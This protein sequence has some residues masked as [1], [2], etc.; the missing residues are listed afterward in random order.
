MTEVCFILQ[1][2]IIFLIAPFRKM[3]PRSKT[4]M[5]LT[6]ILGDRVYAEEALNEPG[7]VFFSC[8]LSPSR[9]GEVK[10]IIVLSRYRWSN[11]RLPSFLYDH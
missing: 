8:F 3:K 1:S 9:A 4:L 2:T 6:W 5:M 11:F 7:N 10:K